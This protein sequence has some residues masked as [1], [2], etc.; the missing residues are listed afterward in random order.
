MPESKLALAK[1]ECMIFGQLLK[2][3]G[4]VAFHSHTFQ[5]HWE[6]YYRQMKQL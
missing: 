3:D 4:F 6:F 5:Y 2:K 1:I